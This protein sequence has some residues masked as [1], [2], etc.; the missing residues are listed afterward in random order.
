VF[1]KGKGKP[2]CNF[3]FKDYRTNIWE[4][5]G[6]MHDKWAEMQGI[7]RVHPT[8]KPIQ[9]VADA[10]QDCSNENDIILD[11]F[12]GSGSTMVAA[13]QT[14]RVGYLAELDAEYVNVIIRRM[15]ILDDTLR[16]ICKG[17]D[18]TD[19]FKIPASVLENY[20]EKN[21]YQIVI[22]LENKQEVNKILPAIHDLI[23]DNP[24][25]SVSVEKL[26]VEKKKERK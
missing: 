7:E 4:Y 13:H 8:M 11:L 10:I 15:L 12:G 24:N 26:K 16:V 19:T 14:G 2:T 25:S 3:S 5:P 20:K 1:Q 22:T 9:L 6:Q 21:K 23:S 18:M 17:K